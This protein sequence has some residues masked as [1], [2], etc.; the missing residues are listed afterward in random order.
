M[1][2]RPVEMK[3]RSKFE[4]MTELAGQ[5]QATFVCQ[6]AL[7]ESIAGGS[8]Q[9]LTKGE[10]RTIVQHQQVPGLP[11]MQLQAAEVKVTF[12]GWEQL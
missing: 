12:E 2:L 4:P 1:R 9:K 8:T 5:P 6:R 11:P 7:I 3:L 10:I